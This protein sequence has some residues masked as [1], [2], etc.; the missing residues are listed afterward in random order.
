MSE[1]EVTMDK[2]APILELITKKID[3]TNTNV[4]ALRTDLEN[5]RRDINDTVNKNSVMEERISNLQNSNEK[6]HTEIEKSLS[7]NWTMTRELK[8][9]F[10]RWGGIVTGVSVSS[11]FVLKYFF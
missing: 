5:A 10:L 3:D 7:L 4:I 9:Q 8:G 11:G 1:N 6:K 2:L